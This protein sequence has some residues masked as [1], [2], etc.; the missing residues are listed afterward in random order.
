[1]PKSILK[2]VHD[3]DVE[4]DV[5]GFV[6]PGCAS[7]GSSGLHM[8]PVNTDQTSPQ[9]KWDGNQDTPTLTPSILTRWGPG[10]DDLPPAFVCHSFLTA[11]VFHF[12]EDSTHRFA[13]QNVPMP[14][15]EDWML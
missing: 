4:Y 15:L 7:D 14:D 12:L 9:W 2:H 8:L 1:M 5:L 10:A 3:D 11:G 13:G 6:C